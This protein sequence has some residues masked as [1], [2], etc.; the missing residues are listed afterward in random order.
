MVLLPT[1]MKDEFKNIKE[2][3][4]RLI[5]KA[6]DLIDEHGSYGAGKR[7]GIPRNTLYRYQTKQRV[8]SVMAAMK[9]LEK[10]NNVQ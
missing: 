1:D 4:L 8:M 2:Q 10:E 7:W 3:H 9:I 5:N 6:M